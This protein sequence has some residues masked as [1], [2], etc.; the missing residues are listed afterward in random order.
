MINKAYFQIDNS[1]RLEDENESLL[2]PCPFDE[3]HLNNIF[4]HRKSRMNNCFV[5]KIQ[6]INQNDQFEQLRSTATIRLMRSLRTWLIKKKNV[7][8]VQ[9]KGLVT[10]IL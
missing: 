7:H 5:E 8:L 1:E 10:E 3:G 2:C 6:E 4:R 9:T